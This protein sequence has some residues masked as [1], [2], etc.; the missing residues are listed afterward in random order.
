LEHVTRASQGDE[1]LQLPEN[2]P[3]VEAFEEVITRYYSL[4]KG[5]ASSENM[6]ELVEKILHDHY[7]KRLHHHRWSIRMNTLHRIE[8]LRMVSLVEECVSLL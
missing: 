4:I 8:K 2:D 5:R 1:E 6:D 7:K 3:M